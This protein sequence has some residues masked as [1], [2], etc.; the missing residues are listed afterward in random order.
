MTLFATVLIRWE[1]SKLES[2]AQ[3]KKLRPTKRKTS[4]IPIAVCH[5]PPNALF[6]F[7]SNI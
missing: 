6:H 3:R 2:T 1:K 7:Q 4:D 5:V